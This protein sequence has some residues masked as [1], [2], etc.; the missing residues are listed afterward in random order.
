VRQPSDDWV[1]DARYTSRLGLPRVLPIEWTIEEQYHK[2]VKKQRRRA[3]T[4][5]VPSAASLP[6][7]GRCAESARKSQTPLAI[8]GNWADPYLTMDFSPQER[9]NRRE[10]EAS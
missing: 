2:K 7:L 8:T 1:L 9:V 5:S 4:I 6:P 3:I 10:H